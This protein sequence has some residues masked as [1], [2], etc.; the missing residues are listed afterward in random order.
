MIVDGSVRELFSV[1]ERTNG[2]LVILLKPAARFYGPG[3]DRFVGTRPV[4]AEHYSVHR[5]LMSAGFTTKHTLK[6]EDGT[7]H[8]T[9]QLRYPDHSG[10]ATIMYGHRCPDLRSPQYQMQ[11]R[12]KD[13]VHLLYEA[14][15]GR[16]TPFYILG[17]A[18]LDYDL[19]R[20]QV[21]ALS[22]H[23]FRF[24][25]FR[26]FAL[27][28][29]FAAVALPMGLRQHYATSLTTING[30]A[31]GECPPVRL[32]VLTPAEMTSHV[33]G[34]IQKLAGDYLAMA[35]EFPFEGGR[36]DEEC[37]AMARQLLHFHLR[38]PPGHYAKQR[39]R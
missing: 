16:C 38:S 7:Q 32:S 29:F 17:A 30:V 39:N 8:E 19:D 1:R 34:S 20:I 35:A 36:M 13:V 5:S 4:V 6:L 26:L 25:H 24:S 27:V 3:E 23:V 21:P 12:A 37:L 33:L 22:L 9:A 2:D 10:Y 11:E 18:D 14:D 28:G 31:T 15:I